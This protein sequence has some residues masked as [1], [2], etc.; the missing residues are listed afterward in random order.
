M[1]STVKWMIGIAVALATLIV[2]LVVFATGQIQAQQNIRHKATTGQLESLEKR[3]TEIRGQMDDMQADV[4]ASRRTAEIALAVA[5]RNHT[6]DPIIVATG[7]SSEIVE[8]L[9]YLDDIP[10]NV[11]SALA[12]GA[13]DV[14]EE[15]ENALESLGDLFR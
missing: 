14:A 4:R 2:A 1:N 5:A 9:D 11:G 10:G 15:V 6:N 3:L 13:E 8:I 12:D 7:S